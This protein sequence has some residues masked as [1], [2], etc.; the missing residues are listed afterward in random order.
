[1]A[2]G[3]EVWEQPIWVQDLLAWLEKINGQELDENNWV[4]KIQEILAELPLN[5]L[6]Q[7]Y[8]INAQEINEIK[9]AT[10]NIE[11]Q[12]IFLS[13]E[14]RNKLHKKLEDTGKIIANGRSTLILQ[15][16]SQ[17]IIS[18]IREIPSSEIDLLNQALTFANTIESERERSSAIRVLA[19]KIPLSSPELLEKVFQSAEA[20]HNS[21]DRSD[22]I[23][24]VSCII[25]TSAPELLEKAFQASEAIDDLHDRVKAI[26]SVIHRTPS[27]E[28]KLLKKAVEV[29]KTI[30]EQEYRSKVIVAVINRISISNIQAIIKKTL[31][32]INMVE[33][34]HWR[35]QLIQAITS[36][37]IPIVET[38]M[39]QE[40]VESAKEFENEF[41]RSAAMVA[42]LKQVNSSETQFV[43]EEVIID[44]SEKVEDKNWKIVL[45][46]F[47]D[48]Y[49]SEPQ[50]LLDKVKT[51]DNDSSR[52]EVILEIVRATKSSELKMLAKYI[53]GIKDIKLE[54]NFRSQ[55][56][57]AISRQILSSPDQ[58]LW[59][60]PNST[61]DKNNTPALSEFYELRPNAL[62]LQNQVLSIAK[63]IKNYKDLYK[64]VR[65]IEVQLN[66]IKADVKERLFLQQFI[67]EDRTTLKKELEDAQAIEDEDSCFQTIGRVAIKIASSNSSPELL[68]HS[69]NLIRGIQDEGDISQTLIE[70]ADQVSASA[71]QLLTKVLETAQSIRDNYS[72]S[73][74]LA[75]VIKNLPNSEYQLAIQTALNIENKQ[76]RISALT[77]LAFQFTE[78]VILQC[79]QSQVSTI[80]EI[81][82]KG[83][84]S[85]DKA[86][87]LSALAPRL[88]V[89]LYPKA[90]QL[91]KDEISHPFYQAETIGNLAPYL[92]TDQ[93]MDALDLVQNHIVGFSYPTT[94]LCYLIPYLSI[95]QL[96]K[97]LVD[98]ADTRIPHL[99][100][101]TKILYNTAKR[102]NSIIPTQYE[103]LESKNLLI[104]NILLNRT[105]QIL[106]DD[107]NITKIITAFAPSINGDY[108]L[109]GIIQNFVA[110]IKSEFYIAQAL[111]AVAPYIS[112]E[113]MNSFYQLAKSLRQESSKATVLS[114]FIS[115]YSDN[116][117]SDINIPKNLQK[118]LLHSSI[119]NTN[120]AL[121]FAT[122]Q[123]PKSQS[124]LIEL[125]NDQTKALRLIRQSL[126][127]YEKA[128]YLVELVPHLL[129][130]QAIE[131]QNIAQEI[132]DDYHR[133]RSFVTL[134][135]YF[136]Q[137]RSEALHQIE[138]VKNKKPVEYEPRDKYL[139]QYIELLCEFTTIVPEQIP[140]LLKTVE[141]WSKVNSFDSENIPTDPDRKKYKRTL[142][143][144]ALKPHL[145]VRLSREIVRETS[146]GKAPQDLWERCL[147]VLRNE[148][149]LALKSGSFRNDATQDE[150]LLDLKDEINALTEMLLMRD[151]TP[152][153]AVGILGGWGGG[154]SY[155]MHLMQKHMVEIRSRGLDLI[156]AWG[157]KDKDDKNPDS[158]RLNRYVGHIYQIKFDAWTYA[159]SDLWSS[160]MQTIFFELDR[161]ISLETALR[162]IGVAPLDKEGN[163]IWEVLYKTNEED[164]KYL[165]EKVLGKD[166]LKEL[167]AKSEEEKESWTGLLWEQ[168]GVQETNAKIDLSNKQNELEIVVS[169][170]NELKKQKKTINNEISDDHK[171][172]NWIAGILTETTNISGFLLKRFFDENVA[173]GLEKEIN[174]KLKAENVDISDLNKMNAFINKTVAEILDE[175]QIKLDNGSK[176]YSLSWLAL[177]KWLKKNQQLIIAFIILTT[178]SIIFP[179]IAHH[180]NSQNVVSQIAALIAPLIPAIGLAQTLYKSNQKWFN[181]AEQSVRE[182][183]ETL[184]TRS[185]SKYHNLVDERNTNQLRHIENEV[186]KLVKQQKSLEQAVEKAKNDLPPDKFTSL[187][188]FVSATVGE[189]SYSKFRSN[190]LQV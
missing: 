123:H 46:I 54:D 130:S 174:N 189:A 4:N 145:P 173:A 6:L 150:D 100:L 75:V 169:K 129:H 102:L 86:K 166:S 67:D 151:L 51:I 69:L 93:L 32:T 80:L 172:E 115:S 48:L 154:K 58:L 17:A 72:R 65:T 3:E 141:E 37:Q 10:Q 16:H 139:I 2:T 74:A 107:K 106:T 116:Q 73:N 70:I 31:H 33:N 71:P 137:S 159:K 163:K 83:K 144:K 30:E 135:T 184:K 105:K 132:E 101:Q 15:R 120:L 160:L 12:S 53:E 50:L 39:L 40:F 157:F 180:I 24:G 13:D 66:I 5:G 7:D 47:A 63:E 35:L 79:P 68:P 161:Q 57:I 138:Q 90:L 143:L 89:G 185:E 188:N 112:Y 92:A 84:N 177:K 114:A 104:K 158:S 43:K 20:F 22:A 110:E 81:V 153:V 85:A 183:Q 175:D 148:Y 155:M 62:Q 45:E 23:R 25:P 95:Q 11:E 59:K 133:A 181:Q 187:A 122:R 109:S 113:R 126:R 44:I 34:E 170:L 29:S 21:F 136:P 127:D 167:Q 1:M 182:Y 124:H 97:A 149:R 121:I 147:F 131:A 128:N 27:S 125:S 119:Y 103:D 186:D 41:L 52:S 94:A 87:L 77:N 179:F 42:I 162:D 60:Y 140:A 96:G 88:S 91:I 146:I 168:Y 19:S 171:P 76:H 164:R 178:C 14:D 142:I 176:K 134:S 26:I 78:F 38:G 9:I 111:A 99:K 82:P 118:G 108:E 117:E 61:K 49:S 36:A 165:L 152:P 190:P 8:S 28:I 98:I 156:E 56:L 55:I 18:V 64:V